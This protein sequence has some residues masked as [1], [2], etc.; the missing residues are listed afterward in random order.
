MGQERA[1]RGER[2]RRHRK[3]GI[4]R[5]HQKPR[6]I[7]ILCNRN[8]NSH[9]LPSLRCTWQLEKEVAVAASAEMREKAEPSTMAVM[10]VQGRGS[11]LCTTRVHIRCTD[12]LTPGTNLSWYRQRGSQVHW[13]LHTTTVEMVDNH[14]G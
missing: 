3:E 7:R 14:T 11:H 8:P 2:T 12:P 9:T 6:D 10:E 4:G 5:S 13:C 1:T